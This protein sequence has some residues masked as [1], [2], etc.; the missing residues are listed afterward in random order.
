VN[1]RQLLFAIVVTS[2]ASGRLFAFPKFEDPFLSLEA[3][4]RGRLGVFALDTQTGRQ[5]SNRGDERFLMCS[6]FKLPLAAA[7]LARVDAGQLKL[8]DRISY[9]AADLP[10]Y[11]PVTKAHLAQGAL[12]LE[13]L[14]AAAV[15]FSDN[16]AANLL[17]ARLG[18][19]QAVTRFARKHGDAVTR[20]DRTELSLNLASGDLDTMTPQA[21]VGLV[22]TILL[23]DALEL[24]SRQQLLSWMIACETGKKRLRA[25]LPRGWRAGDKTG[26]AGSQANDTAIAFPPSRPPVIVCAL[27]D[28]PR[29][30]DDERESV[31]HEVG[32]LVGQ[33]VANG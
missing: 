21:F 6:M 4:H 30:S 28:A 26:T 2:A 25:G 18:G 12:S 29:A 9:S 11:A 3:R 32:T 14:C 20:F 22:R 33:W 16:G 27:Y 15:E 1:R 24:E 23:G 13:E 31:L 5:L 10:G 8:V 17:L 7:V 19:P